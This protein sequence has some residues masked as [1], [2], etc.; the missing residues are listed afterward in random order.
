MSF[1]SEAAKVRGKISSGTFKKAAPSPFKGFFEQV[2]AGII[3]ADEAKRLEDIE[4]R[5]ENKRIARA[6]KAKQDAADALEVDQRRLAS[7]YFTQTG[8]DKTPG[9]MA[10][11]L[12]V[13]QDGKIKNIIELS[14]TM[15]KFSTYTPGL[16]GQSQIVDEDLYNEMLTLTQEGT[17][18]ENPGIINQM[19]DGALTTI[20][21]VARDPNSRSDTDGTKIDITPYKS[22]DTP[23]VITFTGEAPEDISEALANIDSKE[24][25]TAAYNQADAMN[26]GPLRDRTLKAL[27]KIKSQFEDNDKTSDQ[28][29][30]F[31][32]IKSD[33]D[34]EAKRIEIEAMPTGDLKTNRLARY[35][36]LVKFRESAQQILD[37]SSPQGEFFKGINTDVEFDRI[38]SII[39]IM[40]DGALKTNRLTVYNKLLKAKNELDKENDKT[41]DISEFISGITSEAQWLAKNNEANAMNDGEL[42]DRYLKALEL[43]EQTYVDELPIPKFMTETLTSTNIIS[44]GTELAVE[45]Q[46]LESIPSDDRTLAQANRLLDYLARKSLIEKT[47]A[48]IEAAKEQP[49]LKLTDVR[50]D[51]TIE[52]EDEFGRINPVTLYLTQTE[53]GNWYDSAT[54]KLYS[55]SETTKIGYNSDQLDTAGKFANQLKGDLNKPLT[56]LRTGTTSMSKTALSLDTFV[57]NNP[58]ILTMVGGPVSEFLNRLQSEIGAIASALS[59]KNLSDAEF[60]RQYFAL[61]NET[62]EGIVGE[63]GRIYAQWKALNARH[64]FSFAKLALESSGQALS[65]FDYKNAVLINNT[66][67]D[68]LTYSANI[69]K[70]TRIVIET[71]ADKYSQLLNNNTLHKLALLNRPYKEMWMAGDLDTLLI[72]YVQNTN[73]EVLA[74]ANDTEFSVAPNTRLPP[75]NATGMGL[76]ALLNDEIEMDAINAQIERFTPDTNPAVINGFIRKYGR[77]VFGSN[78]TEQQLS[79]LRQALGLDE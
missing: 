55:P 56:D 31:T 64:A 1:K 44:F 7:L 8:R 11:V 34:L 25:W 28:S 45:I 40:P 69:R 24:D 13:V 50:A 14:E 26:A 19:E 18:S 76:E 21:P 32:G 66:G 33:D 78:A 54:A 38:K 53:N 6:V 59:G 63:N 43:I 71:A 46:K 73:P 3:R 12:S 67:T 75:E 10:A 68:Y 22:G 47:D 17:G 51:V 9:N 57:K 5:K 65:N 60:E 58:A 41:G 29:E 74:W 27:N 61:A 70:Q 77:R 72:D 30:F 20:K 62:S 2:S 36:Q 15:N 35:N 49:E 23:G 42:K 37:I 48:A 39:D 52:T 79:T 16:T 4:T